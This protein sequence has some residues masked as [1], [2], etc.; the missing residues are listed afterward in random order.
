MLIGGGVV[1]RGDPKLSNNALQ[2]IVVPDIA[3]HG[4]D[5]DATRALRKLHVNL[6]QFAF[7]L[8]QCHQAFRLEEN[9]LP[10]QFRSNGAPG[11]GHHH[12]TPHYGFSDAL[13]LQVYWLAPEKIFDR[14][15][16]NLT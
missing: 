10:A 3:D 1:D 9:Q 16:A 13:E 6:E 15:L 12:R 4:T 11:A 8:V 14:D 2:S 5:R 7:C